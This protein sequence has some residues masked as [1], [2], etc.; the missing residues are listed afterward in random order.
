MAQSKKSVP[1]KVKISSCRQYNVE[2]PRKIRKMEMKTGKDR[3]NLIRDGR[4]EE[5][6]EGREKESQNDKKGRKATG[7]KEESM[8]FS[9]ERREVGRR[10]AK[11]KGRR[12]G[13]QT[14]EREIGRKKK[15]EGRMEGIKEGGRGGRKKGR[16][17]GTGEGGRDEG[18]KA[19][20][21]KGGME[22][23]KGGEGKMRV[24]EPI[25][26][27]FQTNIKNK[28]SHMEAIPPSTGLTQNS[29]GLS[30]QNGLLSKRFRVIACNARGAES[31]EPPYTRLSP[32][33]PGI[34]LRVHTH[35]RPF[36]RRTRT[37]V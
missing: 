22:G 26:A 7:K 3:K 23:G 30:L 1:A 27:N 17:R 19:G 15:M 16:K 33:R 4:K 25:V 34:T 36:A 12:E 37:F 20:T 32:D 6:R 35:P 13:S 9:L 10:R 14:D 18:R 2:R 21:G 24:R 11:K 29:L 28:G 5:W 8:E 31:M